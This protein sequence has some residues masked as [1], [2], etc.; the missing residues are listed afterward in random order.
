MKPVTII[1]RKK[2]KVP[3][4][5]NLNHAW[6]SDWKKTGKIS[7]GDSFKIFRS[8]GSGS[9]ETDSQFAKLLYINYGSGIYSLIAWRKGREGFWSFMKIELTDQGF[10]RLPKTQTQEGKEKRDTIV[11]IRRLN[12]KLIDVSNTKEKERIQTE[13]NSLKE[14]YD[15][16]DEII[17]LENTSGCSNYLKSTKPL[18]KFHAYETFKKEEVNEVNEVEEFW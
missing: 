11:E 7:Y 14:D 9:I 15:I 5:Y 13:I 6:R 18:Y 8:I 16:N 17:K 4:K 1:I 12:K 3:T 10:L 2:T